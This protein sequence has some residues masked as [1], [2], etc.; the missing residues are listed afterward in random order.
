MLW[1]LLCLLS[2]FLRCVPCEVLCGAFRRISVIFLFRNDL[3]KTIHLGD[4]LRQLEHSPLRLAT[5]R[6][7]LTFVSLRQS[8]ARCDNPQNTLWLVSFVLC[9]ISFRIQFCV[10]FLK[11]T[12]FGRCRRLL[13]NGIAILSLS[14]FL[15]FCLIP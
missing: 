4:F 1:S 2:S 3:Q 5:S 15:W 11:K 10:F 6:R 9:S 8:L 7:S 14:M 13:S 12:V